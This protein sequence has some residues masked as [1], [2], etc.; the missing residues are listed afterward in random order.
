MSSDSTHSL[1]LSLSCCSGV[2]PL[3]LRQG[4]ELV[5][6]E[7]DGE[8]VSRG[9]WD[10]SIFAEELGPGYTLESLNVS[11]DVGLLALESSWFFKGV[12]LI[13]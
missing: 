4:N 12:C 9:F 5:V 13:V 11:S 2:S 8:P 10:C 7:E 6:K 3:V 1:I